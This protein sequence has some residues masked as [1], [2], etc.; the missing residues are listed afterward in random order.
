MLLQTALMRPNLCWITKHASKPGFISSVGQH[1]Y[2]LHFRYIHS[3]SSLLV[4]ARV[5]HR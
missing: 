1:A 5:M 4:G 3:T 2:L